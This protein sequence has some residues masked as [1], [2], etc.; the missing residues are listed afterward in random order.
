MMVRKMMNK[1]IHQMMRTLAVIGVMSVAAVLSVMYTSLQS[2]PV[3]ESGSEYQYAATDGWGSE[4]LSVV[5]EGVSRMSPIPL[6]NAC[7]LG[8]SSCF[9]CHNGQRAKAP[10]MDSQTA[11]WHVQHKKV[12]NSC[13][14]C[15]QGN[16][17]LM[18]QD[19]SHKGLITNPRSETS[20][21]C[22]SCHAGADLNELNK[23]YMSVLG[24]GK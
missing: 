13:V 23:N 19:M 18:K 10:V 24:G 21:S 17:R 3:A 5:H 11:P 2:E 22:A 14:G 20:K 16:P 15:H 7:G 12:N 1:T 8:A 4:A 6:A 9:K